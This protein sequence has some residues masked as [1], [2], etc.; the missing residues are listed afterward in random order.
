MPVTLLWAL[1]MRREI[2][3]Q[4]KT[5]ESLGSLSCELNTLLLQ[6]RNS[7]AIS[8]PWRCVYPSLHNQVMSANEFRVTSSHLKTWC[9]FHFIA[10]DGDY[11]SAFQIL[12]LAALCVLYFWLQGGF[13][14]LIYTQLF[15]IARR[16]ESNCMKEAQQKLLKSKT[17]Q[18]VLFTFPDYFFIQCEHIRANIITHIQRK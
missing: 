10:C 3:A 9:V 13:R 6:H 2:V 16:W 1:G 18:D 11:L 7:C 5:E 4:E 8:Q 12:P 17:D 15:F 14:V